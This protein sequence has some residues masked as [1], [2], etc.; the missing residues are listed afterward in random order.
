MVARP[1]RISASSPPR[2]TRIT[3]DLPR[4]VLAASNAPPPV[5]ARPHHERAPKPAEGQPA[6]QDHPRH[7]PTAGER[8][9]RRERRDHPDKTERH[10]DQQDHPVHPQTQ[11]HPPSRNQRQQSRHPPTGEKQGPPRKDHPPPMHQPKSEKHSGQRR[12]HRQINAD[13]RQ[14]PI[15]GTPIA[16]HPPQRAV[17]RTGGVTDGRPGRGS[18]RSRVRSRRCR[19][20][21]RRTCPGGSGTGWG[22]ARRSGCAPRC[23]GRRRLRPWGRAA[24]GRG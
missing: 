9:R 24:G 11:P 23:A 12:Q 13:S 10:H 19:R 3:G 2:T 22:G 18:S 1:E 20:G 7:V 6:E 14:R 4:C 5:G 21:S 8:H 16:L 17:S 15:D